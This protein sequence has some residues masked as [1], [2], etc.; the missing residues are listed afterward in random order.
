MG[1]DMYLK[2]R[3]FVGSEYE[4]RKVVADVKITSNG[5]EIK[6]NPSRISTIEESVGYWRKANHIHK[7][8]VDNCQDGVDDCR[9][10]YVSSNDLKCLLEIC[11][12]V[13]EDPSKASELLP[14]SS[15]FFFGGTDYDQYYMND[16]D[17][18]IKIIEDALSE[19]DG[20]SDFSYR[21][22]W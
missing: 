7:W 1:L 12:E 6:I 21:S 22:S 19:D 15:G 5:K 11:K 9:D 8:F 3:I 2:K 14:T 13:K 20:M 10:A 4:H 18:T 17:D 16:I